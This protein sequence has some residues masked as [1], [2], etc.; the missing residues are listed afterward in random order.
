MKGTTGFGVLILIFLTL[1]VFPALAYQPF[2]DTGQSRCHNIYGEL[3][4]CDSI[5]PGDYLFGQDTHYQPKV[6]RSY[7]KLGPGGKELPDSAPH[8]SSG[9]EW[10]MTRDNVTGLIWEINYGTRSKTYSWEEAQSIYLAELNQDVML[11]GFSDWRLPD[12]KEL[13]SLIH[14]EGTQGNG[15]WFYFG[16]FLGYFGE[17][18]TSTDDGDYAWIV[19]FNTNSVSRGN[20]YV[21]QVG[22]PV[23]GK[24]GAV[25]AVRSG[26]PPQSSFFDNGDGTVTDTAT[27]LMWQKCSHGQTWSDGQCTG[28]PVYLGWGSAL[29][30][31]EGLTWAN[32][33]DW[34]LPN[35]NELQSLVDYNQRS[36][37]ISPLFTQGTGLDFYF[38]STPFGYRGTMRVDFRNGRVMFLTS[39]HTSLMRAVRSGNS[40]IVRLGSLTVSIE[41][42]EAVTA[43]VQWSV[44]AGLTWYESGETTSLPSGIYTVIF[45]PTTEWKLPAIGN[46]VVSESAQVSLTGN[47][48]LAG[49]I[50]GD[51]SVGPADAVQALQIVIRES[52]SVPGQWHDVNGDLVIGLEEVVYILQKMGGA[53]R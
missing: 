11:G 6:P 18:W 4:P 37:A 42:P 45:Q 28:D 30:H 38:S 33:S 19:N 48:D 24:E 43:G 5:Q 34:R 25:M 10:C 50:N 52:T 40:T 46:V 41:P 39:T 44:D 13:S 49:D 32:Y 27:G 12:V 47:W 14:A 3:K 9:G 8:Q 29:K 1:T 2:P 17:T 51:G 26:P 20:K 7:T 16:D 22:G 31:A 53:L 35:R 21:Y 15:L 36:P 23:K